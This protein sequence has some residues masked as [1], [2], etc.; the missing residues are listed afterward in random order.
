MWK[1]GVDDDADDHGDGN[2]LVPCDGEGLGE[3]CGGWTVPFF[4]C[5]GLIGHRWRCLHAQMKGVKCHQNLD[6]FVV[7]RLYVESQNWKLNSPRDFDH[8][9]FLFFLFLFLLFFLFKVIEPY[10][11]GGYTMTCLRPSPLNPHF[12]WIG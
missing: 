1:R 7:R 2:M 10:T 12:I 9:T 5:Y 4:Q 6:D 8:V 11:R 3:F